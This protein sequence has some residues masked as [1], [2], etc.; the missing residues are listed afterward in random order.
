MIN[1]TTHARLG[2]TKWQACPFWLRMANTCIVQPLVLI[3][4]LDIVFG[5]HTFQILVVVLYLD[6]PGAYPLLLGNIKQ[7][8]QKNLITFQKGKTTIR[9][10]T[11]EKV[12]T[13]QE[14]VPLYVESFNM[15]E[16]LDDKELNQYLDENPK[17]HF[18]I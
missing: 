7:N 15:I 13:K 9:V 10:P 8:W 5:G 1:K 11:Q 6:A 4:Q 17:N 12:I 14:L 3:R 16:G 2:I 18:L